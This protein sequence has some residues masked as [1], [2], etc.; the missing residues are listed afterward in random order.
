MYL[1]LN[2]AD[3]MNFQG[4]KI[5]YLVINR[6]IELY[7]KLIDPYLEKINIDMSFGQFDDAEKGIDYVR[8]NFSFNSQI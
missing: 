8:K 4:N 6:A 2:M 3:I 7:P 1:L 5:C